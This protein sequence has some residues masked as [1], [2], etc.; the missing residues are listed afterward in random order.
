MSTPAENAA[1]S[2]VAEYWRKVRIA[3][4]VGLVLVVHFALANAAAWNKC[5]M[6]DEPSHIASG[7]AAWRTGDFRIIPLAIFQQRWMTLPLEW[8]HVRAPSTDQAIWQR[9]N[10]WAYGRQLLYEL[11]NNGTDILRN[12][13]MMNSL[14]SVVLAGLVFWWSQRLFGTFGG[15]ISL[16]LYAFNPTV[17]GHA[18]AATPDM[19]S[20]LAFTAC[21]LS[22]VAVLNRLTPL[23]LLVSSLLWGLALTSKFSTLLLL[24][25][26]G[27][28]IAVRLWSGEPLRVSRKIAAPDGA[29][30]EIVGRG[31][32]LPYYALVAAAHFVGAVIV[33][34]AMY[35]FRFD[36]FRDV[37]DAPP[38]P[39]LGTFDQMA[40]SA[41]GYE[42]VVRWMHR[43][44]L[45]PEPYLYS[46]AEA[47]RSTGSRVSYLDGVF[48]IYGTPAF[49]PR[50]FL[51]KTPPG[52]F[53]VL[54]SAFAA[55]VVVRRT[56]L[57]NQQRARALL[58]NGFY[59]TYPLW[60]ILLV[61]GYT[62][63]SGPLNIGIRHILPMFPAAFILCGAAGDWFTRLAQRRT[64]GT[65]AMRAITS[66]GLAF[67]VVDTAAAYPNYVAYFNWPAGGINRG[68]E[69]LVDSSLDWGQELSAL[70]DW[71]DEQDFF[72]S[73]KQTPLYLSYFGTTPPSSVT[74]NLL[75][76]FYPLG[77]AD[78]S[79]RRPVLTEL[80]PGVY[81]ISATMLQSLYTAPFSGPWLASYEKRYRELIS[82]MAKLDGT[83][84][85]AKA[86]TALLKDPGLESWTA[87]L[88]EFRQARLARLCA[89]LRGQTPIKVVNGAIL[90]FRLTADDLDH[91]L[92]LEMPTIPDPATLEE[93]I[94]Y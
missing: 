74:K 68:H 42:P 5:G 9:A 39:Y 89:Y 26:A 47:V 84:G 65:G 44:R 93:P 92:R 56:Q 70:K 49:F 88:H 22:L 69:H 94:R 27:L 10:N 46:F 83:V 58:W 36:T 19:F 3:G 23:R 51:Y 78:P 54:L 57:S 33:I 13:R 90:V 41:G 43:W 21:C 20:A 48:S 64:I 25:I 75:P 53:V 11:G 24:P 85:D 77:K 4:A 50:A 7:N 31:R 66:L 87:T 61:Y 52:F 73:R 86:R 82:E 6:F 67:Y 2:P 16:T 14:A 32:Q 72:Q 55:H 79:I 40:A 62:S 29:V 34:W 30:F 1:R 12:C 8:M 38:R 71:L 59:A 45:L 15:F 17:L 60:L 63:I 37:G 76:C 80:Q 91:A 81:C 35:D 28:M 18:A